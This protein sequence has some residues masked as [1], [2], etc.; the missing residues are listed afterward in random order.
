[1]VTSVERRSAFP[2]A[3]SV[4]PVHADLLRVARCRCRRGAAD[5][6]V[7]DVWLDVL[8][9]GIPADV[10]SD[11]ARLR[12]WLRGV[13]AH[14]VRDAARREHAT[15]PLPEGRDEPV[16]DDGAEPADELVRQETAAAVR[17][18]VAALAVGRCRA[19]VRCLE[20]HYLD[21]L[22]LAE[23]AA[24]TGSTVLRVKA[25]LQRAKRLFR[26]AWGGGLDG[27]HG[28]EQFG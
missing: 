26:R 21:G 4:P 23:V 8:L 3:D 18:A 2:A 20:L 19:C 25:R 7:Q 6:R 15:T 5:D 16:G 13:L 1:M 9:K 14:K 17:A 12:A 11:P 24:K 28:I 27:F 22:S 10:A